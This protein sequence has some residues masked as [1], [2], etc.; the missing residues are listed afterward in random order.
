MLLS[1]RTLLDGKELGGPVVPN[2]VLRAAQM[3]QFSRSSLYVASWVGAPMWIVWVALRT[4][5]ET[6]EVDNM[7]MIWQCY[8]VINSVT[9]IFSGCVFRMVSWSTVWIKKKKK[10]YIYKNFFFFFI[11]NKSFF[12]LL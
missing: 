6:S 11:T 12:F 3:V 9:I 1:E 7:M 5:M 10:K 4:R 8:C 2:L